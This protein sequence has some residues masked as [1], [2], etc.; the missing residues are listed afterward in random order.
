MESSF[1][2]AQR[3]RKPLPAIVRTDG[4]K[5]RIAT[6]YLERH[7]YFVMSKMLTI[8]GVA[9][10]LDCSEGHVKNLSLTDGFPAAHDIG[11]KRKSIEKNHR[12]F[13]YATADILAWLE[14]C[15]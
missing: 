5:I 1:P 9:A 10:L 6:A 11:S 3:G 12:I 7:G 13:R 2:A 15:K 8:K 4:E 14:G